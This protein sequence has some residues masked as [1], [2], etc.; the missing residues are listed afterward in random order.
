M[1]SSGLV[2]RNVQLSSRAAAM[3]HGRAPVD[4][5]R[6]EPREERPQWILA[7]NRVFRKE[8]PAR[9]VAG[10]GA[11]RAYDREDHGRFEETEVAAPVGWHHVTIRGPTI[12]RPHPAR[13]APH[14][15]RRQSYA[16]R[17]GWRPMCVLTRRRKNHLLSNRRARPGCAPSR[18]RTATSPAPPGSPPARTSSS[19][20]TAATGIEHAILW[21]SE[22]YSDVTRFIADAGT[23]YTPTLTTMY[24]ADAD[25]N[26][27]RLE[28]DPRAGTFIVRDPPNRPGHSGGHVADCPPYL[29]EP[30]ASVA[31]SAAAIFRNVWPQKKPLPAWRASGP[32]TLPYGSWQLEVG[33]RLPASVVVYGASSLTQPRPPD[34][35]QIGRSRESVPTNRSP[36]VREP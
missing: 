33:V 11:G 29:R 17:G 28:S 10:R 19:A 3:T 26:R 21:G 14:T 32:I 8:R 7:R 24:G 25:F 30:Y 18:M 23:W 9:Q 15:D 6:H 34:H 31:R 16:A 12:L 36:R 13:R 22:L 2:T 4:V 35:I 5:D 27:R 20:L 1:L